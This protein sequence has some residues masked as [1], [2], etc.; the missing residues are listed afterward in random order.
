MCFVIHAWAFDD[1]MTF[2]YLN[3]Y[4]VL[5]IFVN[6]CHQLNFA[7]VFQVNGGKYQNIFVYAN[8]C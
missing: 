4:F 3:K 5:N 2:E 1:V 6:S 7:V 8:F